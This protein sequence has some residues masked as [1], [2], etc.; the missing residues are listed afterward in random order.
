[1]S[2]KDHE[3]TT[4]RDFVPQ[5]ANGD[6]EKTETASLGQVKTADFP[7]GETLGHRATYFSTNAAAQLSQEHR[8]YLI[9]RHGTLDLD[10][11]PSDDPADPCSF[12]LW[13]REDL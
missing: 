4:T 9:Q 5:S 13:P 10:P 11:M 8:D 1:M 2:N 12:F 7:E 6:I 3:G